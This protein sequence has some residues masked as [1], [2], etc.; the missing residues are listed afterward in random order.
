MLVRS[1]R[2]TIFNFMWRFAMFPVGAVISTLQ[3]YPDGIALIVFGLILCIAW[4]VFDLTFV[5]D[6]R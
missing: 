6:L 5:R 4:M 2:K 1:W 3:G